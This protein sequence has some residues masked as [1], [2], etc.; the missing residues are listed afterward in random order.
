MKT[1]GKYL[2]VAALVALLFSG[3]EIFSA[4]P[5]TEFEKQINDVGNNDFN[6]AKQ[7]LQQGKWDF[8]ASSVV[9][10]G[11]SYS[12]PDDYNYMLFIK[13]SVVIQMQLLSIPQSI[14]ISGYEVTGKASQVNMTTDT[15]GD[16]VM[17][18]LFN[19]EGVTAKVV[20]RVFNGSN[21]CNLGFYPQQSGNY[22]SF[23]G[24]LT[25]SN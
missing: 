11:Q 7:A 24:V 2:L 18:F 20:L 5:Q 25:P 8:D 10:Y 1:S 15:Q 21:T 3:L 22:L 12:L 23:T 4:R 13:D 16:L 6:N 14:G 19:G 17:S 9:A